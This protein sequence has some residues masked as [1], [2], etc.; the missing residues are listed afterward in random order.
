MFRVHKT[1]Q[2]GARIYHH[3]KNKHNG[4]IDKEE[5]DGSHLKLIMETPDI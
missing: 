3:W 2:Q 5:S 4:E 1:P